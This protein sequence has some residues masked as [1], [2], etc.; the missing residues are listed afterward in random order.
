M[1]GGH[2]FPCQS[3][4]WSTTVLHNITTYQ[5]HGPQHAWQMLMCV[6][7]PMTLSHAGGEG[8]NLYN[9]CI[10]LF[11]LHGAHPLLDLEVTSHAYVLSVDMIIQVLLTL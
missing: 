3:Y 5:R 4:I 1:Y 9:H 11:I 7:L 10:M 2:V 8:V 6:L